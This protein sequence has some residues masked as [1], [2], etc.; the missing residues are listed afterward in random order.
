MKSQQ[1]HQRAEH[2]T[3]THPHKGR[4]ARAGGRSLSARA[5]G[6][7]QAPGMKKSIDTLFHLAVS[8]NDD[9]LSARQFARAF[10]LGLGFPAHQVAAIVTAL[11]EI[12]RNILL[13]S[14]SGE[15]TIRQADG[16]RG[17]GIRVEASDRGPGILDLQIV[18]LDG[19][20]MTG[21]HAMGLLMVRRLM[22]SFAI[23]SDRQKG[24]RVI[25]EKWL[26]GA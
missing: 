2:L 5:A 17:H 10:A 22:D 18:L 13:Y 14:G 26:Q 9:L 23:S 1:S 3:I 21:S 20:T 6:R 25:V 15:I 24:T 4:T 19:H 8:S 12:V 16:T 11:S 7:K